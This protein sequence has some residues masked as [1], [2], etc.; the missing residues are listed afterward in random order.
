MPRS[1]LVAVIAAL[2][3][4]AVP[5]TG[6]RIVDERDYQLAAHNAV[7]LT[8]VCP[9]GSNVC[10]GGTMWS[11]QEV[12]TLHPFTGTFPNIAVQV[13][14]QDA[15]GRDVEGMLCLDE[16]GDGRCSI[17]EDSDLFCGT[18]RPLAYPYDGQ[19]DVIVFVGGPFFHLVRGLTPIGGD[20]CDPTGI[21]GTTGSVEL[22][23]HREA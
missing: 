12:E 6:H 10:L 5:A 3:L 15:V 13:T 2:V 17:S 18:S 14:I 11:A 21:G 22:A 1:I 7:Q 16:D 9:Q 20:A 23:I 19:T 8:V 4:L